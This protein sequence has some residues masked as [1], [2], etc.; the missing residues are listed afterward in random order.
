M[1]TAKVILPYF[2]VLDAMQM[3]QFDKLAALYSDWNQKINLISRK[4]MDHLYE[5]HLLHSLGIAKVIAFQPDAK[6]LDLGTGGGLPGIP[7]AI[8]FPGTRFHLVDSIGK[9][10]NAVQAIA[11]ELALEN[12]TTAHQR[13]EKVKGK[14]DFVVCRA[15]AP[16]RQLYLWTKDKI[17]KSSKHAIPNGL[18]C[19]KGGDLKE[20]IKEMKR[21]CYEYALSD[22]FK[23]EFFATK[24]VVHVPVE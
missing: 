8:M 5:R 17:D 23:E 22:Y 4:D 6:V 24:K 13:A 11:D 10:I 16:L 20:E 18:I 7:L 3:Q 2:P 15:V 12:V 19:L 14:Y 9:K 1:T 21:P